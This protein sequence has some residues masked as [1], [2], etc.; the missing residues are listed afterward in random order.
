[1]AEPP[2]F[3]GKGNKF[4]K[5]QSGNPS[6]RCKAA[7]EMSRIIA[8][9]TGSGAELVAFALAVMRGKPATPPVEPPAFAFTDLPSDPKSRMYCH[10][11]LTERVAGKAPQDVDVLVGSVELTPQQAAMLEALK[12]SPH[13]RRQRIDE[14]RARALPGAV[15]GTVTVTEDVDDDEQR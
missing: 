8:K 1:M 15:V 6:G 3:V 4:Q 2:Q 13:E 11:W 5:G 12:M 9:E 10:N 14:L 7:A